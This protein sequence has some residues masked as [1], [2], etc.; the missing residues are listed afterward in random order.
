MTVLI[1]KCRRLV[2]QEMI[3]QEWLICTPPPT[4]I[5]IKFA[6]DTLCGENHEKW[7]LCTDLFIRHI[8]L[9]FTSESGNVKQFENWWLNGSEIRLVTIPYMF[10]QF[11]HTFPLVS[12][13]FSPIY[14]GIS[15]FS[16]GV[17]PC[18]LF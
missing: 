17:C 13:T 9:S 11:T 6:W 10:P 8:R 4:S 12:P 2:F 7:L 1:S 3:R 15:H 14:L 5:K 18:F 16:P